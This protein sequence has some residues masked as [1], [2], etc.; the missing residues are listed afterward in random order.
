MIYS[1]EYLLI[2][3]NSLIQIFIV[4][5]DY[6]MKPGLVVLPLEVWA[7]FLVFPWITRKKLAQIV[8]K[9]KNRKFAEK[10]QFRL[11][12]WGKQSLT[13]L[14]ISSKPKENPSGYQLR[15]RKNVGFL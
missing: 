8:H 2:S 12:D 3:F 6:N 14:E 5:S 4:F 7:D 9:F 10:L 11:H 15:K 1:F 13:F